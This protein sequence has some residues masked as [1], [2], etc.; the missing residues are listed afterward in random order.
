LNKPAEAAKVKPDIE[1]VRNKLDAE[2]SRQAQQQ[3][4]QPPV[5]QSKEPQ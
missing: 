5:Q 1:T 4:Q 2:K 3:P